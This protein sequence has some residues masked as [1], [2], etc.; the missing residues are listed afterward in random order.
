MGP[1]SPNLWEF[2]RCVAILFFVYIVHGIS[3]NRVAFITS[4]TIFVGVR[5]RARR[6]RS[7]RN[8]IAQFYRSMHR[9]HVFEPSYLRLATLLT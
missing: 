2:H 4:S 9:G 8:T 3:V 7:G 5:Y 6:G 1:L